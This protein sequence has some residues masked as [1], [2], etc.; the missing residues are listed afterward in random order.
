MYR[1]DFGGNEERRVSCTARLSSCLVVSEH[2]I[3][4]GRFRELFGLPFDRSVPPRN[5]NLHSLTIDFTAI[6]DIFW[7]S[8]QS[9]K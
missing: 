5:R 4:F 3:G 9:R 6:R 8:R 1:F 7:N 2:V